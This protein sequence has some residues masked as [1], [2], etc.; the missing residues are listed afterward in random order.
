MQ[1][2][3]RYYAGRC[4]FDYVYLFAFSVGLQ[5]AQAVDGYSS[6]LS[7]DAASTVCTIRAAW[8]E[9]TAY[10]QNTVGHNQQDAKVA[11]L[12]NQ[13]STL[14]QKFYSVRRKAGFRCSSLPTASPAEMALWG[15]GPLWPQVLPVVPARLR[16]R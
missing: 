7:E 4:P 3:P 12:F 15:R 2:I 13:M 6:A 8:E 14:S 5:E 10:I 9:S 11:C 16:I 1:G